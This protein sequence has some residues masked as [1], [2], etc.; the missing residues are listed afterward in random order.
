IRGVHAGW[1]GFAAVCI[2]ASPSCKRL[3]K[4]SAVRSVR[5]Q[6]SCQQAPAHMLPAALRGHA[7]REHCQTKLA[8]CLAE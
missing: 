2:H 4:D 5:R 3:A 6:S 1:V 7:I 8:V